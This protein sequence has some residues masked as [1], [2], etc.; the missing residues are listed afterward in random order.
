MIAPPPMI[1][2]NS[3]PCQIVGVSTFF[4]YWFYIISLS[5]CSAFFAVSAQTNHKHFRDGFEVEI[6]TLLYFTIRVNARLI[7]LIILVGIIS[8]RRIEILDGNHILAEAYRKG[9]PIFP[10]GHN[11]KRTHRL[12]RILFHPQIQIHCAPAM[13]S[14]LLGYFVE[15]L[16]R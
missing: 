4:N 11:K 15:V 9:L 12:I 14:S 3:I 7:V 5:P 2:D 8:L 10:F 6:V 13:L 16:I 1:H